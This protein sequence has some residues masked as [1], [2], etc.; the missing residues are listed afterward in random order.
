M[1]EPASLTNEQLHIVETLTNG[2][3]GGVVGPFIPL[4]QCPRLLSLIEPLG[5]ELRFH[6][7]LEVRVRE[8]VI[9]NVARYTANQ[10]EW[11]AHVPLAIKA[12]VSQSS[13]SAVLEARL[14]TE[15]PKD[16][17][18]ALEFADHLMRTHLVPDS[19]YAEAKASFGVEGIIEL[20]T[21]IGYFVAV[22]WIMNVALTK[23]DDDSIFGNVRA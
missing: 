18:I 20:T 3:R 11:T 8:I 4:I 5:V 12:G 9:C 14:P 23:S 7:R 19:L 17:R 6:G 15:G 16:E 21:L 13:I 2:P 22:C 1:P 10:F